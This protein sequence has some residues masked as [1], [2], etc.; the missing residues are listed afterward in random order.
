MKKLHGNAKEL[1][2]FLL[3]YDT[4]ITDEKV[5]K[6]ANTFKNEL[7]IFREEKRLLPMLSVLE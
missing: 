6:I 1:A 5:I 2:S 4:I 7:E 3:G